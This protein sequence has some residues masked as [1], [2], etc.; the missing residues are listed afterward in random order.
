MQYH[1]YPN[2]HRYEYNWPEAIIDTLNNI[3]DLTR[4]DI[5]KSYVSTHL[6]DS[7]FA[8][9]TASSPEKEVSHSGKTIIIGAKEV[10][11]GGVTVWQ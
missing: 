2:P 6:F 4:T 11:P 7:E 8:W 9:I 10:P 3:I 5:V 1:S